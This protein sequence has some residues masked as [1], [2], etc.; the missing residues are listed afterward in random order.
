MRNYY[1]IAYDITD[2]KRLNKVHNYLLGYGT[3][4]QYSIFICELSATER[5][6]L[7]T[8]I[9]ALIK[10]SEDSIIIYNAGKNVNKNLLTLGI[11]K[12]PHDRKAV[13]V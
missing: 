3:H 5:E 13:I 7:I 8:D 11:K 6:I 10:P 2:N 9:Y 4:L 12:K 1:I